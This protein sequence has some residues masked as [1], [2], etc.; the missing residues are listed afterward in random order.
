MA[1]GRPLLLVAD[2]ELPVLDLVTRAAVGAGYDV[3]QCARGGEVLHLV[4]GRAPDVA[5]V[6]IRMPDADGLSL[7]REIRRLAPGCELVATTRHVSVE[8]AVDAI[9]VGAREYIGKP[10]NP[11][12]LLRTLVEIRE[13][14][15]GRAGGEHLTREDVPATELCGM[16]GCGRAMQ[17]VFAFIRRLAPYARVVLIEGETGTGKEL[18]ARALHEIGPRR[19]RPFTTINC[20][21]VVGTLFESELFGHVRGAFTG[22]V[23]TTSG[24]FEAA[25]GGTIFLD[26]VGELPL[27]VQAK[28]LRVLEN[29]EIQRVGSL[30][31]TKVDV[32]VIAATNRNLRSE[33]EA[34]RF[35]GDLFYRLDV[36]GLS[37]PPLRERREDIPYLTA[38]F[39]GDCSTR[40]NKTMTGLTVGAEYLLQQADWPGNVRE[41]RNCIERAALLAP[42]AL[43]SEREVARALG[44]APGRPV[45][46][47][48]RV[49]A[50][51]G[52]EM[53]SPAAQ[54]DLERGHILATLKRVQ[55]NRMAAA[56]VLGISRRA[57][58]RRLA[59][60]KIASEGP[61]GLARGTDP[62]P[63]AD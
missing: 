10:L 40:F 5:I 6:D 48:P 32:T 19:S 61:A 27:P 34:G 51:A 33:V 24:L 4:A 46:Q 47:F 12:A 54:Q 38:A 35:R 58:Y 17:Q 16:I 13:A 8:S 18:A 29:G 42:G 63:G 15:E 50:A 57:L 23:D 30:G 1:I 53:A 56:R 36:A 41:L 55:G 37:L 22:A 44:K 39:L 14:L 59:R 43:I 11:D 26:E 9:H 21:A 2:H 7:L 31:S 62:A 60:Y 25:S 28:L 3:V 49:R 52:S 45:P 20:S